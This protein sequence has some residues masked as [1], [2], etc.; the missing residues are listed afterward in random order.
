LQVTK[1]VE[2]KLRFQSLSEE[3]VLAALQ[4]PDPAN[5]IAVEVA[6]LIT[7]YTEN[8]QD[9]VARLGRIPQ[10]ILHIK[11]RWPIEAVAMRLVTQA[12][13]D[14]VSKSEA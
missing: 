4:D 13:S 6:R 8:F 12:I 14:T 5:A 7:A 1:V 10:D 3:A 11:A 9:H 2:P